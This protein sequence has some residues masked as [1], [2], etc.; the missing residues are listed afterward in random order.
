MLAYWLG[1]STGVKNTDVPLCGLL[2]LMGGAAAAP[3][4]IL[5]GEG[6]MFRRSPKPDTF[7]EAI[8]AASVADLMGLVSRDKAGLMSWVEG[9]GFWARLVFMG[10][11]IASLSFDFLLSKAVL[12]L[13][14]GVGK[15]IA[16]G[17]EEG[18]EASIL[19]GTGGGDKF[20]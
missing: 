12:L 4:M 18:D 3:N 5:E 13:P 15:G 14:L 20:E 2:M 16:G 10:R 8:G 6:G 7:G 9:V 11:I 1:V 17:G 19:E